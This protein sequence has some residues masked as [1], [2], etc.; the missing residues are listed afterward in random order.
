MVGSGDFAWMEQQVTTVPHPGLP[1][2]KILA[3]FGERGRCGDVGKS[4]WNNHLNAVTAAA[5]ATT[6][7]DDDAD[8]DDDDD[9]NDD[10][11]LLSLLL[12]ANDA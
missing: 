7:D 4:A 9:D 8:C 2:S 1:N 6:D 5:A 12:L 3:A 10:G 11:L